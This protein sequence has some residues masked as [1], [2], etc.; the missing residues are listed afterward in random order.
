V[1]QVIFA[2]NWQEYFGKLGLEEFDD[3][4]DYEGGEIVNR[5]TKRNVCRLGLGQDGERKVFY[6]KRFH[7]PHLKDMVSALRKFGRLTSQAR[8]EWNNANTLL[9]NGIDT[10]KPVCL[11]EHIVFG[12]DTKSFVIT[13]EL[14]A[15]S[16][17]D[18]VVRHW[19]DLGRERQEDM[20]ARIGELIR[21]VH[22]LD[23]SLP[24]LYIWH[25][26]VDE[27]KLP[28]QC[29]LSLIDLHRMGV[30]VTNRLQ[31][32]KELGRLCW[33]MDKEYFDDKLRDILLTTYAEGGWFGSMD[34]LMLGVRHSMRRVRQRRCLADHYNRAIAESA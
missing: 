10:Y 3:F 18:Y 1:D 26:F 22:R 19:R 15:T 25:V 31:K 13:E 21:K 29:D 24:D 9:E 32:A 11:G 12:I 33:S 4:Y 7:W 17:L 2:D 16:M 27:Q 6:M 5:N 34:M 30:G 23:I 8:V 20:M 14:K 28:E